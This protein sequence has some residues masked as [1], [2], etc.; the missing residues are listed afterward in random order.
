MTTKA[1]ARRLE[2]L[3][4]IRDVTGDRLYD[5]MSESRSVA[6]DLAK[7]HRD[8]LVEHD[9]W[10]GEWTWRRTKAGQEVLEAFEP[11]EGR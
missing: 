8:G 5:S 7:L 10:A 4:R 6:G 1:E 3:R 11:K 2:V 9:R